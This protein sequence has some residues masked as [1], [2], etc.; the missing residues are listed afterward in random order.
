[1]LV[2]SAES[3]LEP[4]GTDVLWVISPATWDEYREGIWLSMHRPCSRHFVITSLHCRFV[5]GIHGDTAYLEMISE[6][7][8]KIVISWEHPVSG[9]I[10]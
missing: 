1:M 6:C 3:R 8:R 10:H 5:I 9:S 7:Q 4:G 2:S